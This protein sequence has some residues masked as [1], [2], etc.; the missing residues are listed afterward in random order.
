MTMIEKVS[1]GPAL[2]CDLSAIE[3]RQR[4]AH[5]ALA[6]RLFTETVEARE[7][8]TA[9]YAFRFPA[10]R[11]HDIV[12][13]IANERRCCPFFTFTLEVTADRG[14]IWLRIT[15]GDGVK[16]SIQSMLA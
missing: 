1:S 15:G 13:F 14:P 3:P 4:E 16:A 6:E 8:I 2:A 10:E 5:Q 12:A 7:E 9:G 11:Y